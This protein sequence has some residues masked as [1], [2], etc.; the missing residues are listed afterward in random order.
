MIPK[1][2]KW[3]LKWARYPSGKASYE[4]FVASGLR[5]VKISFP[6]RIGHLCL[7]TDCLI[8]ETIMRGED[9]KRLVLL[10]LGAGFANRH[11]VDYYRSLLTVVD[12][13]PAIRF[14]QDF[15]DP[16]CASIATHAFAVAMYDTARAYDVYTR[17]GDRPALFELTTEDR[18]ALQT[19]LQSAGMPEGSWY[20]CLHARGGGYSPHDESIHK[21]R[22][23]DIRQFNL[24]VDEITGRGG[25]VVRM[26]DPTMPPF[27]P[28][29]RVIDYALDV[30]KT[31]Q[32]DIALAAGCRFF[33]GTASGLF[34]VAEMFGRP[35]VV[36]NMAPLG[37]AYAVAPSGLS[38]PQRLQDQRGRLL[39]L[40]E[41]MADECRNFRLNEEFAARGL[42]NVPN[43]P[44]EIVEV[45]S[46]M[47]DRMENR[48]EYTDDDVHRQA[49]FRAL[50]R[51]GDYAY[52]AGSDIG[53]DYLRRYF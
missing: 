7:E 41:I 36:V 37:G 11:I 27:K 50:F 31:P 24:A 18:A 20:V 2:L 33:L 29:D 32:L 13:S 10:D 4:R 49:E 42:T 3:L 45:T 30:R 9:P 39:G 5:A 46:E 53:R 17:W 25:W 19:Y 26:G 34:N 15:G 44:E 23:V 16:E 35:C 8:K 12:R 51:P 14:M 22:T 47:L 21:F 28:R 1:L 6:E 48:A 38:I 52:G 40:R 43:S